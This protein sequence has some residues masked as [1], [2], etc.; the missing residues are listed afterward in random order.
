MLLNTII[1][2][3]FIFRLYRIFWGIRDGDDNNFF[4]TLLEDIIYDSFFHYILNEFS[5]DS[6]YSNGYGFQSLIFYIL[7]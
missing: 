5:M 7:Y 1:L 2:I 4:V 6:D 3:I